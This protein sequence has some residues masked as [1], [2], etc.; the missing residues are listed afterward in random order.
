MTLKRD[1]WNFLQRFFLW[2]YFVL[3]RIATEPSAVLEFSA[4]LTAVLFAFGLAGDTK[5]SIALVLMKIAPMPY[6]TVWLFMCGSMQMY[7][8]AYSTPSVRSQVNAV[9]GVLWV[10]IC[11][12]FYLQFGLAGIEGLLIGIGFECALSVFLHTLKHR[13]L[14]DNGPTSGD[15]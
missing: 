9:C 3:T 6:W 4:G 7:C 13:P 14:H 2:P 10:M 12:L 15:H 8:C 1:R 5:S 11:G